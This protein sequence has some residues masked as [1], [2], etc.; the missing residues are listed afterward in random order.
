MG[1]PRFS[2]LI[3]ALALLCHGVVN[4]ADVPS[5]RFS[6]AR[7]STRNDPVSAPSNRGADIHVEDIKFVPPPA[8]APQP[9]ALL[10]FSVVNESGS[11]V[12]DLVIAITVRETPNDEGDTPRALV[13]PFT[14]GGHATIEVGYSVEYALLLRNLMPDCRCQA[15]VKV[16]SARTASELTR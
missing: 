4:A 6:S 5:T 1:S 16:M 10:K 14:V 13:G 15:E 12:S 3:W 7:S 11:S 8:D 9:S 2:S